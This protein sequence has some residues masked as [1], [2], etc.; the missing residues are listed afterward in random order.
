MQQKP[1]ISDPHTLTADAVIGLLETTRGGLDAQEAAR[2]LALLGANELPQTGPPGLVRVFL[3]QFLSPLIY[4]LLAAAVV[5]L[6]IRE[7]SDAIFIFAVLLL[8]AVIGTAQEYSAQKAA[9]ALQR[10]VPTTTRVLRGGDA[11]ELDAGLLVPGDLVFLESGDR[12]PADLRLISAHELQVD[13]S[14]LTGES[15]AVS[16]DA[17]AVLA[18]ETV[19]GDRRNMAFAG[20]LVSRGRAQGVVTATGLDTELGRIAAAVLNRPPA[21]PPLIIRIERF[22]LGIAVLVGLAVAI[23]AAVSLSR[24]VPLAE[25]FL[26]AVAL[27][28]SAIPEG[29]PVAITVALSIGVHRMARRKV[30]VRRLVAVEAL[31]SAT[32]IASDK[33][34]TLTVNVMTVTRLALPGRGEWA[35]SGEGMESEGGISTPEGPLGMTDMPLLLRLCLSAVM[36]NDG[37]YGHRDGGWAHHGDAV[38]VALLV[39]GHKVGLDRLELLSEHPE[40]DAIPFESETRFSASLNHRPTCTVAHVKGALE[41]VL[42]MCTLEAAQGAD[43]PLDPQAI[44]CQAQALAQTGHRVLALASGPLALD[45]GASFSAEHLRGLTFLGLVG[46]IDPLRP[47]VP[48]AVRACRD[49][50]IKVAMVTG[51]H[52]LTAEHI[53]RELGL[54]DG[55]GQ[56]MT[57]EELRCLLETG[58]FAERARRTRVFARVEPQEKLTIVN[59]LQG[60]GHFVAATGDG[61]NDAPA[62][63]AAHVGVAMGKTGTDVARETAEMIVTDDNFA[64][65]VA[66]VE[67]G[68]IAYANVRKV[69]F[70]LISTGMAEIVLFTLALMADLPL[71]LVAVQLLWLNLVTNGIQDVALGFEPAEG[72]ELKR[73]PRPPREPIFDRLMVERTLLSALYM[74]ALAFVTYQWMLSIGHN[75]D[76]ARNA[77]LLL[78][79]LFENVHVFNSRSETISAFRH[80]PLGNKLLLFGTAIAQLVHVTAMYTPGL[81][82]VLAIQPVAFAEWLALLGI[83]LSLLL[84]MEAH[85]WFWARRNPAGPTGSRSR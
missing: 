41:C 44:E 62:L 68:R 47:E 11:Y 59:M 61:A 8:N 28:V 23:L 12:L 73:P 69:I 70:L 33:T 22:T 40:A 66:G 24:G 36:A 81:S 71:P 72:D 43:Q 34:G 6:A 4:I 58:D 10:L 1:R 18:P 53:A 54:I 64:S 60:Q 35:V 79:V 7:H 49:A 3:S 26:L 78:M 56:V 20:T 15:L 75:I 38:D 76:E 80:N 46:M 51:D 37:F 65:I 57:G 55:P 16:K 17:A 9:A 39:L 29:L 67:E 50:G 82:S 31:G 63:R 5:S 52:P 32:Y 2:R 77:I 83:A 42:P 19:V 30:I 21:K 84:V 45:E 74:G 27:A 25:I 13:E 85:K 14:L 48:G